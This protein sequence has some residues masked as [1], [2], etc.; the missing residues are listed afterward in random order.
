[1]IQVVAVDNQN[2]IPFELTKSFKLSA[3]DRF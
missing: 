3:P 2:K 1:M